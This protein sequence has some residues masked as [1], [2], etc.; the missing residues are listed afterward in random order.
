[1]FLSRSLVGTSTT[2]GVSPFSSSNL[3]IPFS[4]S[5]VTFTPSVSYRGNSTAGWSGVGFSG[6][7]VGFSGSGVGFSGSGVGFSGFGVGFSGSGVGSGVGSTVSLT[8]FNPST[9]LAIA[10]GVNKF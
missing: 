7:G 10:F 9:N 4:L 6:S 1:M 5:T 3:A 8:S 2:T